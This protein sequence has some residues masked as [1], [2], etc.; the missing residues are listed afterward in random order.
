MMKYLKLLALLVIVSAGCFS[1]NHR[2][3]SNSRIDRIN[4]IKMD[5]ERLKKDIERMSKTYDLLVEINKRV[6]EIGKRNDDREKI[7][8]NIKSRIDYLSSVMYS[9]NSGTRKIQRRS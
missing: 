2:I 8:H 3:T 4:R 7:I 5:I 9:K 1:L 6:D